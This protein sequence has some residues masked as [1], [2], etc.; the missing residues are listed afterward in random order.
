MSPLLES[1]EFAQTHVSVLISLTCVC[2]HSH[3]FGGHQCSSKVIVF[4]L[5]WTKRTLVMEWLVVIIRLEMDVR[6]VLSDYSVWESTGKDACR[7][8]SGGIT[9][10]GTWRVVTSLELTY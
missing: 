6:Q 1:S 9:R 3:V 7:V 10:R 2:V 8:W 4:I 5:C